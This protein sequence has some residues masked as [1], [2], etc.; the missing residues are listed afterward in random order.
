MEFVKECIVMFELLVF[1]VG[2]VCVDEKWMKA[3]YLSIVSGV[4]GFGYLDTAISDCDGC[5]YGSSGKIVPRSIV[6][7]WVFKTLFEWFKCGRCD[8]TED[9]L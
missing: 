7:S 5:R 2:Y 6:V 3:S 4:D 9:G 1:S 8:R